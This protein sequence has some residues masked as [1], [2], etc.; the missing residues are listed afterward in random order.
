VSYYDPTNVPGPY[1]IPVAAQDAG[2]A[3]N[4]GQSL[5]PQQRAMIAQLLQGAGK[6]PSGKYS[7]PMAPLNGNVAGIGPDG[8]VQN[9]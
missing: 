9:G 2:G 1:D 3:P 4:P 8:M 7:I 6:F 5:T